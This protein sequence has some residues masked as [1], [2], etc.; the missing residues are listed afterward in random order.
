[1]RDYRYDRVHLHSP[2]PDATAR[3]HARGGDDAKASTRWGAVRTA[4][5]PEPSPPAATIKSDT[6]LQR[7]FVMRLG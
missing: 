2:D 6:L 3:S 7:L 5:D 4:S 1:M